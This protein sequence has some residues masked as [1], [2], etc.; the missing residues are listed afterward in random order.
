MT[1]DQYKSCLCV[2]LPNHGK[3]CGTGMKKGTY[4]AELMS[5]SEKIKIALAII[6]L[7]CYYL[8]EGIFGTQPASYT[9]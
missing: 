2:F 1:N 8:S 3:Y 5:N 6:E 4:L 7:H 9:K